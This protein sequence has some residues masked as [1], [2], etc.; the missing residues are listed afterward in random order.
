MTKKLIGMLAAGAAVTSATAAIASDSI[1]FNLRATV[2]VSCSVNYDG[3]GLS[4]SA[5]QVRL[6]DLLEYCNAP[7]GYNLEVRYSPS[8]L[9]GVTLSVGSERVIL[10]GS[11]FASL[12]G[13][14]G[15]KIQTRAIS[16]ETGPDGFDTNML[17]I[18]AVAN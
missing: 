17:Q 8:S 10:D 6:G 11:G 16:A 14:V 5:Q 2:P 4:I 13:S 18:Q 7:N 12:R 1:G 9:Q 3:S 15:P